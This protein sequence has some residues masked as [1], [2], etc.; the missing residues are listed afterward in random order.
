[1]RA[2]VRAE[3][4]SFGHS[5]VGVTADGDVP[6]VHGEVVE[7]FVN[8]VGHGVVVALGVTR[9]DHA[10]LIHERHELWDISL[11]FLVPNGRGVTAGLVTCINDRRND[12]GGHGFEL[13]HRHQASGVLGTHDVNLDAEVGA[14]VQSEPGGSPDGVAI[15]DFFNGSQ[16][17]S[18]VG[19]FFAWSEDWGNLN[20]QRFCRKSL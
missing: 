1:M 17:L 8:D 9:G 16:A 19:D 4:D 2:G 15:K 14:G 7:D 20:A 13:L 11:G 6:V 5:G 10:E 3:G 12:G 18:L